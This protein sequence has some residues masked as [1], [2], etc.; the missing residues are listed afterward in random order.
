MTLFEMSCSMFYELQKDHRDT[1]LTYLHISDGR[2]M[3]VCEF[4]TAPL[5]VE[6]WRMCEFWFSV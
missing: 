6:L 1:V 3:W 5:F 4:S 2:E